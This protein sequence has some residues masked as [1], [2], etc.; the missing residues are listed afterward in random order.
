MNLESAQNLF[1]T[2]EGYF[3]LSHKNKTDQQ[4]LLDLNTSCWTI[5]SGSGLVILT[6]ELVEHPEYTRIIE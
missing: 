3:Y 4:V 1:G 2:T 5:R 6:K